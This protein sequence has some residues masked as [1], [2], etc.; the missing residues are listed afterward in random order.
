MV[1]PN[2]PVTAAANGVVTLSD[3]DDAG[4]DVLSCEEGKSKVEWTC[5][6]EIVLVKH[7]Q[8]IFDPN[9]STS[10]I[11]SLL[12]GKSDEDIQD[13]WRIITTNVL[14]DLSKR[15]QH[16]DANEPVPKQ[17]DYLTDDAAQEPS[18]KKQKIELEGQWTEEDLDKLMEVMEQYQTTTPNWDD[19]ATNFPGKTPVDCLTQW[20]RMSIPH[21]VKGKGSWTAGED[22]ILRS[23]YRLF[24]NKWSKISE[25]LPGRTGKQCRERFMNHLDPNLK[26]CEWSDDEEAILIGMHKYHGNKWS[27]I[28]KNLPGRSDNDVKNHWYST[29]ARKFQIHGEEKLTVAAQQQ[30]FMLVTAGIVSRDIIQGW[31][32]APDSHPPPHAYHYWY[33]PHYH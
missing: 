32:D 30:V 4:K 8:K 24:G 12:E 20:Q 31:P 14:I 7:M 16:G 9:F 6:E 15:R 5:Q 28:A 1:N 10:E 13:K 2:V 21:Q 25:F 17:P 33:G 29:I 27:I 23:K 22:S 26:K 19:V 3:E 18:N 11:S